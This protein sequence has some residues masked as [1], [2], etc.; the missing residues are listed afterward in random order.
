VIDTENNI[1]QLEIIEGNQDYFY[2]V[3]HK[4]GSCSAPIGTC[5]NGT[6]I[7]TGGMNG[8]SLQVYKNGD[9]FNFY[10]DYNGEHLADLNPQGT[11]VCAIHSRDYAG[12][13]SFGE[14]QAKELIKLNQMAIYEHSLITVRI[15]GKWG[16]YVSGV[17]T[18]R[19]YENNAKNKYQKFTPTL[20]NLI[21]S[22]D[23]E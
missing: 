3:H 8:C 20:S 7:L 17:I 13:I 6:I 5:Q 19:S 4:V 12:L 22:F 15:N 11:P 18:T 16:I 21:A 23:D 9:P 1:Y 2:P 10:H 14:K